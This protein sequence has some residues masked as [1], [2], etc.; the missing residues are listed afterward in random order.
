MSDVPVNLAKLHVWPET[1][2]VWQISVSSKVFMVSFSYLN[3]SG[4]DI[5]VARVGGGGE[6]NRAA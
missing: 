6:G 4:S 3:S 1:S 5:L 2:Q